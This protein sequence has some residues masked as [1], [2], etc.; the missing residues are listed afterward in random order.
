MISIN[1]ASRNYRLAE[2]AHRTLVVLA[3][4]ATAAA[5]VIVSAGMSY[6]S[7]IAGLEQK[8]KEMEA[9]EEQIQPLLAERERVVR[10]LNAM[11]GLIQSRRFSWT[12]LLTN[13][14]RISPIGVALSK[15]E[16]N[17]GNRSLSLDGAA[18]T[19]ES[20]RNLMV[21]FER[22]PAFR[23]AY[24]KNQSVDK[25]SISFNVVAFYQEHSTAGVAQRK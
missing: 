3:V 21:G 4:L 19:P 7:E 20:L 2:T 23:D 8:V 6:R 14:E 17:P 11:S 5:A 22:T 24:L 9:A 10:D 15:V 13:I 18:L 25:G 1:F 16:Y 12:Q